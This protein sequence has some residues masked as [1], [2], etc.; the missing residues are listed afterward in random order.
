MYSV[1][2]KAIN[3]NLI[4]SMI[5]LLFS[6]SMG[7]SIFSV[8]QPLLNHSP[9]RQQILKFTFE[10]GFSHFVPQERQIA[11]IN[12]YINLKWFPSNYQYIVGEKTCVICQQYTIDTIASKCNWIL[13]WFLFVAFD[14][15]SV[16]K[17][18]DLY[19]R[20][21]KCWQNRIL[22]CD[23]VLFTWYKNP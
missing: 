2:R 21:G 22:T 6:P 1:E 11:F 23:D 13:N 5:T 9:T 4:G 18:L 15:N 14:L 3:P 7:C 10:S 19:D 16:A 8:C 20:N 12:A 17:L